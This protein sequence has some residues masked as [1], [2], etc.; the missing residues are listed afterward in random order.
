MVRVKSSTHHHH[1]HHHQHHRHHHHHHPCQIEH[2]VIPLTGCGHLD[3]Q[4]LLELQHVHL[5]L[6]LEVEQLLG[7]VVDRAL[8]H[9]DRDSREPDLLDRLRRVGR[10]L[11]TRPDP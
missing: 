7:E 11:T 4:Q 5:L 10:D 6:D 2:G 3:G 8:V 1:H 9:V